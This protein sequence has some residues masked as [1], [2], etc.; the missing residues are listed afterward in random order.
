[1]SLPRRCRDKPP[2]LV[3][4]HVPPPEDHGD[5]QPEER[6]NARAAEPN[7]ARAQNH[8]PH[9]YFNDDATTHV[10]Q[11]AGGP[12][13]SIRAVAFPRLDGRRRLISSAPVNAMSANAARPIGMERHGRS[14]LSA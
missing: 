7:P 2:Q 6:P 9:G 13:S 1:M 11:S 14:T 12:L 4:D 8:E 10:I 3:V 5:D